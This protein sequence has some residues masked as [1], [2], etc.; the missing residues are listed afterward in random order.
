[1]LQD[2]HKPVLLKESI[3]Y[4]NPRMGDV[5]VD[6][7]IGLGGH[8][9][10]I[11][12]KIGPN[13]KLIGFDLDSSSLE[14][15]KVK[16]EKYK[17]IILI[18]ENFSR[19]EYELK[20][21]GIN[22]IDG[23]LFDFGISSYQ[24]DNP[25][26][27]FSF[28]K[29][30]PLDMRINQN[31]LLTAEKI[32][33]TFGKYEL[34]NIFKVY[35]EERYSKKIALFIVETRKKEKIIATKQ[36]A[37]IIGKA[38]STASYNERRNILAR[39]FQ[40]IR[41]RTNHELEN[42]ESGLIAALKLLKPGGRI[43]VISFHSLEDKIVKNIFNKYSDKPNNFSKNE[44]KLEILTKKIITPD[45]EEIKYNMRSKNSKLRA[46]KRIK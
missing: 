34:E 39:I 15:S 23:I 42:I 33:N 16:F 1:M 26:R 31:Q 38:V 28:Q 2:I 37:G 36:F 46:G 29:D 8:A 11:L 7:T 17:N 20:K 27:G 3:Y 32:I 22:Y 10:E 21:R 12:E 43:V 35:G 44:L 45:P 9:K 40:A 5:I 41:I 18:N 30:G 4:L 14:K 6:A 19:L 25:E 13:G 24:L